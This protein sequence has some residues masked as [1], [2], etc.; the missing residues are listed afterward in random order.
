[1]NYLKHKRRYNG[2]GISYEFFNTV[3]IFLVNFCWRKM[4]LIYFWSELKWVFRHKLLRFYKL[5]I[6]HFQMFAIWILF[7]LL[8]IKLPND[9]ESVTLGIIDRAKKNII[10]FVFILHV[11]VCLLL[12]HQI[13]SFFFRRYYFMNEHLHR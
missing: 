2:Y 9:F 6:D 5:I 11:I 13:G 12:F 4:N 8:N 3:E 7:P 10:Y 1:M